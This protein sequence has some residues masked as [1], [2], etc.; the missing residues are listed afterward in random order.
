MAE[1]GVKQAP[2]LSLTIDGA[3]PGEVGAILDQAFNIGVRTG[4]H[5]APVAH[6]TFGTFPLGTIRLSP[7]YYNTAEEIDFTLEAIGKIARSD[8]FP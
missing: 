7:G 5:C 1:G 6:K 3:E 4:L 2:I 8:S